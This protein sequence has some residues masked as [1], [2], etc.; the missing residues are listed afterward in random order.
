MNTYY[1]KK[2]KRYFKL[3]MIDIE[4]CELLCTWQLRFRACRS[5][6]LGTVSPVPMMIEKLKLKITT[7]S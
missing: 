6:E 5:T 7:K 4:I 3:F 2:S 1:Y